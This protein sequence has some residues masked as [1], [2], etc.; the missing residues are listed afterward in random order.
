MKSKQTRLEIMSE[1]QEMATRE[2]AAFNAAQAAR[3][4][5]RKVVAARKALDKRHDRR[6]DE[7][8]AL[9]AAGNAS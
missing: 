6:L 9:A 2:C 8:F 7:L 5:L 3:A 4:E 1:S